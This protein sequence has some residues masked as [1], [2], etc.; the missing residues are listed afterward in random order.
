MFV[1]VDGARH[2]VVR[3]L[4]DRGDLPE[5]ARWVLEPGGMA[6]GTTV[7]PSKIGRAHV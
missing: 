7:Y 3:H 1:L 5:M 6:V 2:D 4:L